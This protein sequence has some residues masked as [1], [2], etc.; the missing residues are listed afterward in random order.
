MIIIP[1]SF[2]LKIIEIRIWSDKREYL[3]REP[4]L[5]HYEVKNSGDSPIILSFDEFG[6]YFKI[7][8]EKNSSYANMFLVQYV[9][10]DTLK[11]NE[12]YRGRANI[13]DRY[14]IIDAGEYTIF[15]ETPEGDVLPVTKSNIIKIKVKNPIGEEKKVLDMFLE[16]E[17]LEWARD[18]DGKKDFTKRELGFQKYLEL[19]DKYPKSVYAPLSLASAR[20]VY[21]YSTNLE[22]R[23]K[24]IPLCIRLLENYP[25]SLYFSSAFMSLVDVY[26][27]LKDKV[28]AIESM[29]ELIKKH[30]NT[31]ILEE[32]EKRLQRIEE[33]KF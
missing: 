26:E 28:G 18:K 10:T 30:P 33:W 13:S 11:P 9:L 15:M 32:A 12:F 4:I 31:K 27:V 14:R 22:E 6:E 16:A 19:V 17:R 21:R 20:G 29:N 1:S 23:K 25:N 7:K 2:A 8:D 5:I 24:I 3:I